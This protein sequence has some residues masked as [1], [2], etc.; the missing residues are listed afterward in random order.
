MRNI[1]SG[2]IK[3][4]MII[5]II[6][7]TFIGALLGIIT[8]ITPGIHINLVSVLILTYSHFILKYTDPLI[9]CIVIIGMSITHSFLDVIPSI[10]LG[11]PDEA[12]ALAILPGHRMLLEGKGYEAIMLTTVGSLGSLLLTVAII[13]L[14]LYS[15][16]YIYEL[17]KDYI[18]VILLFCSI[19]LIYKEPHSRYWAFIVFIL[20]GIFGLAVLNYPP[21]KEPLFPLLSGLFGISTLATSISDNVRIPKQDYSLN[22]MDSN[23]GLK[24][25]LT[26]TFMGSIASFMP[27]LG[28]SQV[29]ILGSQITKNLKDKGFLI[30]IG[31]LN[32]VNMIV[33]FATLQAIEKARNGAVIVM[34]K[35]IPIISTEILG[36][37]LAATLIAALPATFL[38]IK[39]SKLF[40]S[41]LE[42][43]NYKLICI[44]I[45]IMISSL[46]IYV[47]GFI[48]LFILAVSTS[49]GLIPSNKG[50]GKNH[51]MGCLLLPIMLYFLL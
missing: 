46:V 36:I 29:A 25:I 2:Y 10:F 51:L 30:L 16:D 43:T 13:P 37:F 27:G 4:S 17:L 47:C 21:L 45:L 39:L 1:N 5:E 3:K 8:G 22:K 18:G 7:A 14:F 31:G 20:S 50:I 28:P 6:L 44:I 19:Y 41:I 40:A 26:S 33:S 15:I 48:G 38:T 23:V 11:A 42:K 35:I 34:S 49:I 24:A 32:T 12:T 9:L